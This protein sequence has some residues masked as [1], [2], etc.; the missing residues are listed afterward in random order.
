MNPA[1]PTLEW[2]NFFSIPN[3]IAFKSTYQSICPLQSNKQNMFV[4]CCFFFF[5]KKKSITLEDDACPSKGH[6]S[7]TFR[8]KVIFFYCIYTLI[9]HFSLFDVRNQ[10]RSQILIWNLLNLFWLCLRFDIFRYP[11]W[12][13]YCWHFQLI[14]NPQYT[15]NRNYNDPSNVTIVTWFIDSV[16]RIYWIFS[17]IYIS[18]RHYKSCHAGVSNIWKRV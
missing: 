2:F 15:I 14:K 4:C 10:I 11:T 12:A 9:G 17:F 13:C 5:R 6:V 3:R 1:N 8:L 7:T 18:V 16:H